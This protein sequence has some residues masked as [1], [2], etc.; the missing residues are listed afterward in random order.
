MK[1]P[2]CIVVA[3]GLSVAF[4]G[5]A[6]GAATIPREIEQYLL[7][8]AQFSGTDVAALE[9]GK[10]IARV[11][12]GGAD[13][14]LAVVAAVKIRATREQTVGYYGRMIAYVDGEVTTAFGRFS[15]PPA[16]ADVK[17]LSLDAAE[18]AQLKS[19]R[20]RDCDLR[21]GG[22]GLD[23]I[24]AAID[25]NAPDAAARANDVVRQ[26]IVGYIGAYLR[27][28]NAA[29]VTYNDRSEAVSLQ[30]QWQG[31]L[32]GSPY[33]QQ[34]SPALKDYL[35]R[36]PHATLPGARDV[37]YWVKEDYPGLKPVIS[38]VHGVIVDSPDRPDRTV[39]AQKQLYA[40]HYYDASLA[41]ATIVSATDAATPVTYLIYANRSRGDLMKGGFGGVKRKLARETAKKGAEDTLATIKRVLEEA[42]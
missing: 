24:R 30:Q 21:I 15:T 40:S 4:L 10:V 23:R 27:D 26:S 35:D 19:C 17:D 32:A 2:I 18:I 5:I 28:G 12:P 14:E 36:F 22:A 13:T 31:L 7:Q 25:W 37:L 8:A 3:A 16:L 11:M 29:L 41:V 39:V 38:V 34:Y 20:P 1:M 33:F 9:G 6:Q 42:R